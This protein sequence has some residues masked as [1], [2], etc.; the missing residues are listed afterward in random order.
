VSEISRGSR[1]GTN[2]VG[3]RHRKIK[4]DMSNLVD[5]MEEKRIWRG[6]TFK[7]RA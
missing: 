7:Q 2:S 5:L 6:K 1:D 4:D 3:K